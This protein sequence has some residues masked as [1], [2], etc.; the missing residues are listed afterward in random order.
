MEFL[1][2]SCGKR[3]YAVKLSNENSAS[4]PNGL[5]PTTTLPLITTAQVPSEQIAGQRASILIATQC[6]G[7]Y[8]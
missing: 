3:N 5:A 2:A 7:N 1:V 4:S 6:S 8:R